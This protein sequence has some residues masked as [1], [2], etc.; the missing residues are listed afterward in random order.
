[1]KR[2]ATPAPADAPQDQ[3]TT[4]LLAIAS[5]QTAKRDAELRRMD[6]LRETFRG[7]SPWLGELIRKIFHRVVDSAVFLDRANIQCGVGDHMATLTIGDRTFKLAVVD[8]GRILCT[9][10]Y[11]WSRK[12][13][14]IAQLTPAAVEELAIEFIHEADDAASRTSSPP[15]ETPTERIISLLIDLNANVRR[16]AD[17]AAGE[18]RA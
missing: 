1:M 5:A 11:W 8:P 15:S 10:C 18:R 17:R 16:L 14:D 7:L 3:V 6:E 4:A 9:G 13:F 2:K 12:E